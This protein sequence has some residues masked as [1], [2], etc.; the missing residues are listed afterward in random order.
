M[1]FSKDQMKVLLSVYELTIEYEQDEDGI[2]AGSIEQIDD[3][4]A[5][6][7][8]LGK[9]LFNRILK[10]QLQHFNNIVLKVIISRLIR[11]TY[12]IGGSFF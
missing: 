9:G 4:V 12:D 11:S 8:S 1:A 6:A 2:Y 3:L 7:E 10:Q 5:E